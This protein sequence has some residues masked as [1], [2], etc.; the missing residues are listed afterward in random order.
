[1]PVDAHLFPEF[2]LPGPAK[3]AAGKENNMLQ[4]ETHIFTAPEEGSSQ[5]ALLLGQAPEPLSLPCTPVTLE[6]QLVSPSGDPHR[7]PALPSICSTLILQPCAT[8]D[9]LLLQPQV[10]KVSD[11]ALVSAHSEWQRKLEAAEAL[12]TLRNSAQA[13]PDSISLHQPCN[14]P[15]PAGDKGFQPPS[16]SL[17]PRPASSISLPIGH[18]GCIS[19]LS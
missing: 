17:R 9:P 15:A 14:P 12:L 19:L 11:Q 7:A 3:A 8:L 6:Q 10:P 1:M 13:P 5:G 2:L 16:P 18:L 4:P